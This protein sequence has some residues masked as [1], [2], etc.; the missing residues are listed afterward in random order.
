MFMKAVRVIIAVALS[1]IIALFSGCGRQ[2]KAAAAPAGEQALSVKTVKA[3]AQS[4]GQYTEYVSTLKSR[5]SA[6][7]QPEVEGQITK[8]M[9]ASGDRVQPGQPILEIDPRKQQAT[10]HS[11]EATLNSRRA[12]LEWARKELERTR[13]LASAGV[14]SKQQLDQAQSQFDAAE[15]DVR[16]LEANV[17]E[18][19]VQLHYYI[20]N[21]PAAGI[22]GDIPVR[23][24]DRVATTTVLTTLDKGGELE[25]YIY[26]P[27]E[28]ATTAKAGTPVQIVD[29]SGKK[30]ADTRISFVSPRVDPQTQLLLVKADVA[31][32]DHRFRNEQLVHA[33]VIYQQIDKPLIPVTAVSRMAGQTFAFVAESNGKQTVA[34][35]KPVRLGEIVGNS[36][37]ILDGI[38]PGEQIITSG[39]QM[40]A[41]GMPVAPQS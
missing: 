35:Q 13:Q 17:R 4:V 39:V 7:L 14:V 10:V 38:N 41:D 26:I 3:E 36:Y 2:D 16:A 37:V 23:I 34:K 27:A 5:N 12:N 30:L 20:V 28:K 25:A 31:N 22:I 21:A 24:G 33:R 29:D 32:A 1:S 15:A 8:I 9:V 6:V 19:S 18:Q 11:Q 40:L